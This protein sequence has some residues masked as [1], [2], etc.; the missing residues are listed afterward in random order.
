MTAKAPVSTS[1]FKVIGTTP[2]RHDA[3]DKV[4]GQ[5]RYGADITLPGLLH[6]KILRSPHAHA[7]IRSIDATK[8]L[9]LPG[10][11]A[12][13]TSADLPELSG[14]PVD[15]AEGSPL[16]P[17]FL[18]N[19]VLAGGKVLY[20]GHAVAGVA[21][22]SVHTAEKA[23]SLIEVDYEVLTPVLDGKEAMEPGAPILHD[24]L[25]RSEGEYFRPGGLR[26][27]DDDSAPTNIAS[28][29]VY[30]IGDTDQGFK[31][32]DV[33]V[34]REFRT[35]PVH[36][37]YIEPHSAT[38]RWDRDGRLTVWG[39]SQGHF[40]IRDFTALVLGVPI[41][42][43]KVIPMEVGGGFGGKLV[44]YVEPVAA[45]LSKKSG[46]PVKITMTR[47]EVFESTGP[48]AGGYIRA[49]IGATKEGRITAADA[50]FVYEAGAFPGALVN[51][52]SL[53]I[54]A[55]YDIPNVRSEG[56]DVVVNKPKVAPYRAPLG[57]PAG[58]AGETLIDELCEKLSMDPID[59]RLL[60]AAK[61]GTRRASGI[62][63]KKVGYI[64]TLKAAKE[65]PHYNAPLGG[66]NRGRG[67]ATAVCNNITGP[68]SAV[69]SLQQDGSVGLVEGS[70]DLAGS[71][72][73]AAMH[74]AEVLGI[75]AEEVHPS[76]GDTDSIGYTAISAGSSAV[77]KTGWA[78]FEAA[79]DLLRQLAARAALIW[80]VPAVE[81]DVADGV[82]SHRSDPELR[83]TLKELAAR[84]NTTGGPMS[85]RASGAWGGESP[86][87]AVHIVDVEVDPETGKTD[88]IRYTALQDPGTAVH[89]TYVEGQIQG[90][91]VQG[92]GWALNE[93]YVT[94]DQGRM[95]NASL[96]DYRMPIAKDLPMIDT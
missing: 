86:G 35:R 43:V 69:V 60:N 4:T 83:L 87:F 6:G 85:G 92:I 23:L 1:G 44:V 78:S 47:A 27:E 70:V 76:V 34:E 59:F 48:T 29:F 51:L 26:D 13:V 91:A 74:V 81:V 3:T 88:I 22:D 39:S 63:F 14:R 31:E 9:A 95:L 61:E 24:R 12:V 41:S 89:P 38:A 15:V 18:S 82:F 64:E 33:I 19:N 96:L 5:A 50:H 2:I 58:F 73:A 45:L 52:A 72:T 28:H 21:A 32:A 17:R 77:Y 94:D 90:G 42:Q 80:E 62:P 37:G 36:Q 79:R 16:N 8:A 57:P 25:F 11:K 68:A 66:P 54:F 7:K 30:E 53:T 46:R 65:H 56:Y 10:V 67:V 20:Q 49:R 40:A 93:V 55:P 75:A 71:R 84:Q